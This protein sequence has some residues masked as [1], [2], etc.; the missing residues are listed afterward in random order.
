MI[1]KW[2]KIIRLNVTKEKDLKLEKY[3]QQIIGQI[4]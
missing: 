2:H 1:F 4:K 3:R